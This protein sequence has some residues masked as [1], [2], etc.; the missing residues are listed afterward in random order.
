MRLHL[1]FVGKTAFRD[2]EAGINR[3]LDRLRFYIPV[4]IHIVKAEKILPKGA[5]EPIKEREAERILKLVGEKGCLVIWD[6]HGKESDSV[7]FAEFLKDLRDS[8][9]SEVWMVIGG[10]L[11]VSQGLLA[12]A[13]HVLALS[14]MTFPHDLARLM[15]VEQLYRAFTILKGEAYHK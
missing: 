9:I 14:R 6:Q 1:L 13:D 15:V 10:P 7:A 4:Q 8:G 11:G 12:R 3:F 2:L 5:E